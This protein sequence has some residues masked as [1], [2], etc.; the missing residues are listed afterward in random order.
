VVRAV[1]ELAQWGAPRCRPGAGRGLAFARY[2]NLKAYA[3]I[4]VDLEVN[5]AAEVCLRRIFIAADAG[6]IVDRDG[7]ALQIE[8]A[9]LQSA[10]WTLYEQVTFDERGISSL[11][12]ETYPVLRFDN[13]PEVKTVLIDRPGLPY[14]GPSECAVGPTAAAIANAIHDATGLRLQRLPFNA[15]AIRQAA[16]Q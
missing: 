15:A 12:W 5:D 9:A 7:L 3:A 16:L 6:Q 1:A 8:G 4:I 11:D 10:S 13:V 14:L 2:N